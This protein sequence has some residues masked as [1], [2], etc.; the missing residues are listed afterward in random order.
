MTIDRRTEAPGPM[1]EPGHRVVDASR[2]RLVRSGLAAPVVLGSLVSKPVLGA[3]LYI[4]T[5]S[6]HAS[7]NASAHLTEG[8]D[9]SVGNDLAFWLANAWPSGFDKGG[10]P[11]AA[12]AFGDGSD[13]TAG[14]GT[15]FNG[16]GGLA[17]AF[18]YSAVAASDGTQTAASPGKSPARVGKW[19]AT[20]ESTADATSCLVNTSSGEPASMHQVLAS[21][22]PDDL[23]RLGRATVVSLLNEAL[24][25]S[26]YPVSQARIVAMFNAVKDGG[27]YHVDGA[28][29]DLT[30]A[31]VIG[32]L[33]KLSAPAV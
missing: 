11:D 3:D 8:V 31:G 14:K 33:E 7:G 30:Q 25:G 20:V 4:C 16:T 26:S 10:L 1:P 29:L 9:C 18:Y 2:R 28:N 12:C 32:Y 22:D 24:L 15:V 21:T 6:G 13:G 19:R 27:S 5:L 17:D 23:F